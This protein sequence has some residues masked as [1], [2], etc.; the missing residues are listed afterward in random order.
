M[1]S[2]IWSS[3]PGRCRDGCFF[4]QEQPRLTS[5]RRQL[6]FSVGSYFHGGFPIWNLVVSNVL[7]LIL[8]MR[9]FN[10]EKVLESKGERGVICLGSSS[11]RTFTLRCHS[12]N[13]SFID[14]EFSTRSNRSTFNALTATLRMQNT[15]PFSD[16][17]L[18]PTTASHN[19]KYLKRVVESTRTHS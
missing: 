5:G 1:V 19:V 17:M 14:L 16:I 9:D 13:H 18:I 11:D 15:V 2:D 12:S 6:V 4:A 7:A 3:L 10:T 8:L